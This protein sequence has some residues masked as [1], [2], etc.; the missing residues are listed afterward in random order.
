MCVCVCG[1]SGLICGVCAWVQSLLRGLSWGGTLVRCCAVGISWSRPYR[2]FDLY[3]LQIRQCAVPGDASLRRSVCTELQHM[4]QYSTFIRAGSLT[5]VLQPE[6]TP[7]ISMQDPGS[8]APTAVVIVLLQL[9]RC[10]HSPVLG[11]LLG[12]RSG[13]LLWAP[14]HPW[15]IHFADAGGSC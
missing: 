3:G 11:Q 5:D 14:G 4:H 10:D 7:A 2:L 1:L 9:Q 8:K 13:L 12:V 15:S 6:A